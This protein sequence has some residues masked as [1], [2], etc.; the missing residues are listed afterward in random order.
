MS[1]FLSTTFASWEGNLANMTVG[2]IAVILTVLISVAV[3][4]GGVA[5]M[6]V[7]SGT[8]KLMGDLISG[9][10]HIKHK[11]EAGK[12]VSQSGVSPPSTDHIKLRVSSESIAQHASDNYGTERGSQSIDDTSSG[13]ELPNLNPPA[14]AHIHESRVEDLLAQPLQSTN[15]PCLKRARSIHF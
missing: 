10:R 2:L 1:L 14:P 8:F 3:T 4:V 5:V 11:K 6:S 15:P 7:I 13:I 9:S 12:P